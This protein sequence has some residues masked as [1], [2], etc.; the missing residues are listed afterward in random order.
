MSGNPLDPTLEESMDEALDAEEKAEFEAFLR[1]LIESGAEVKR[2][3][4]S[5]YLRAVKRGA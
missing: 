2:R 3:E 4:A 5:A 1:G